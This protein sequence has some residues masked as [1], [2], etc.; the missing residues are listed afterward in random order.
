MD[1]ENAETNLINNII[2]DP[3]L[4]ERIFLKSTSLDGES[5]LEFVKAL[6]Q[7]NFHFFFFLQEKK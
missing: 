5:V 4:I 3:D 1:G 6:C 2:I 7:V